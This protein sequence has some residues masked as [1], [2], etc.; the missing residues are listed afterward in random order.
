MLDSQH[1]TPRDYN[2]DAQSPNR[3]IFGEINGLNIVIT[4]LPDGVYGN[5][6]ATRVAQDFHRDFPNLRLRFLV[7]IA[8]GAPTERNDV[9]LGDVVV[10]T[11]SGTSP[12][13]IKHDFV[14]SLGG[15]VFQQTGS[16]SKPPDGIL[17]ALP[18]VRRWPEEMLSAAVFQLLGN[19]F[20]QDNFKILR[21]PVGGDNIFRSD[22]HHKGKESKPCN[23]ALLVDRQ[24]RASWLEIK[25]VSGVPLDYIRWG[26]DDKDGYISTPPPR[27]HYGTIASGDSLVQDGEA[28]KR[29]QEQTG[30][31]CFEM[32]AGGVMDV[33]PC[34]VVRG[35]CVYSDSDKNKAWQGYAAGTAA[36]FTKFLLMSISHPRERI[37]PPKSLGSVCPD[38]FDPSAAK[39]VEVLLAS[40]AADGGTSTS[41]YP[42]PDFIREKELLPLT[43]QVITVGGTKINQ[44]G[45]SV[46]N[47]RLSINGDQKFDAQEKMTFTSKEGRTFN[48]SQTF[49]TK[50]SMQ[51]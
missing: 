10:S 23:P 8:D 46:I 26:H 30:A 15:G 24:P 33:W 51:F 5:T 14:K 7:G 18:L 37:P 36:A 44:Y 47:G 9:R 48:G 40:P 16:L 39:Y 50:G 2:Y 6:S 27:I 11:P 17:R 41:E 22:Y 21:P 34:L 19:T 35:I 12:G 45:D 3:Y 13:V 32:E 31:L 1:D 4:A 25:K 29:V 49:I 20:E 28:R 42:Q 38:V 43:N